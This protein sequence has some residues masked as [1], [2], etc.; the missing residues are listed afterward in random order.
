MTDKKEWGGKRPNQTG[1]PPNRPGVRR[2]G[3]HCMVDPATRDLIKQ[4]GQ[5]KKLSAGQ[6]VDEL[7]HEDL[8]RKIIYETDPQLDP[9][10]EGGED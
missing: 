1:R 2:V 6:V 4:I 9:N 8:K 3:F 7:V 5:R 10:F